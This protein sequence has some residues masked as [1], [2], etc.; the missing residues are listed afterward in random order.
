M[1]LTASLADIPAGFIVQ[2]FVA[3]TGGLGVAYGAM[4]LLRVPELAW[5]AGRLTKR[6]GRK[7]VAS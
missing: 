7:R 6:F 5:V 3:G 1:Q 2:L 4:A